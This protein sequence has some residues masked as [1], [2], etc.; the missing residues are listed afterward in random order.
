M[1]K[2]PYEIRLELISMAQQMVFD[3]YHIKKEYIL[4]QWRNSR[5]DCKSTN[6]APME[7]P[8]LPDYPTEEQIMK[9]AEF[10]NNFV[11]KAR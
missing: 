2:T 7:P 4:E 5:E 9:K 6:A 11:S 10:L 1:S 3:E 8:I